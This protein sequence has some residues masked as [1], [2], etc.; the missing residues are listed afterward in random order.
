MTVKAWNETA[1]AEALAM[2]R[3][4]G[5]RSADIALE[6]IALASRISDPSEA[7]DFGFEQLRIHPD[8]EGLLF[9]THRALMWAGRAEEGAELAQRFQTLYGEHT[10]LLA[11][12]AY[13]GH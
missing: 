12:Q 13:C 3:R 1:M 5:T 4:S 9:Q 7:A 6:Y 2:L 8:H 11:R 10:L